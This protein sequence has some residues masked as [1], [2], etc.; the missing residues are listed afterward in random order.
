M[1]LLLSLTSPYSRKC[2]IVIAEKNIQNV[3]MEVVNVME[4][5][6]N[7]LAVN[8]LGTIPALVTK[9][10]MHLTD[11]SVICEYLDSLPSAAP[12]LFLQGE[13]RLCDMALYALADG[14]ITA[15]VACVMESR[16]PPEFQYHGWVQ[17]KTMAASRAIDKLAAANLDFTRGLSIGLIN[18][19]LALEYAQRRLPSIG[20][21]DQ[22]P[23]LAENIRYVT[24]RASFASTQP[25]P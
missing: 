12:K 7:L 18:T 22:Y 25:P 4:N 23:Q 2:R 10:G 9:D 5:P 1:K 11:S 3:D 16:R 15:G 21:P 6:A 8:P 14:I 13:A 19:V 24:A 20:W 17:R